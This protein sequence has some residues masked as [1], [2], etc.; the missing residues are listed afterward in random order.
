MYDLHSCAKPDYSEGSLEASYFKF[1]RCFA[2]STQSPFAAQAESDAD[3][4][5]FVPTRRAADGA[6]QSSIRV[7]ELNGCVQRQR[8]ISRDAS[9]GM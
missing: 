4:V 3:I 9:S 5:A 1:V 7:I 8:L 6:T 2:E